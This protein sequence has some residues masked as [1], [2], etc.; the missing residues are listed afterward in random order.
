MACG[1]TRR[2]ATGSGCR[3]RLHLGL[4]IP[5]ENSL[6][7]L[8][9]FSAETCSCSAKPKVLRS[10]ACSSSVPANESRLCLTLQQILHLCARGHPDITMNLHRTKPER[11]LVRLDICAALDVEA[12]L[13]FAPHHDVAL[14][15]QALQRSPSSNS[16]HQSGFFMIFVISVRRR[17]SI[18]HTC[19]DVLHS[20]LTQYF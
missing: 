3:C 11:T 2:L 5:K 17:T 1:T 10:V 15:G 4:D 6:L 19:T 12:G 16:G 20:S 18:P 14:A 8:E 13:L 9:P 7:P